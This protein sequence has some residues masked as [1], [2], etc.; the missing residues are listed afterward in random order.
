MKLY[1]EILRDLRVLRGRQ[2]L[3]RATGAESPAEGPL[4]LR[5]DISCKS[6]L[7]PLPGLGFSTHGTTLIVKE[8]MGALPYTLPFVRITIGRPIDDDEYPGY[9]SHIDE[10]EGHL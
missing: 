2:V 10:L 7:N 1:C 9:Q 6:M 8:P 3:Y 5:D 4:K